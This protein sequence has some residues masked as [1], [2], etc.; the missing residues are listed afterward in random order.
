VLFAQN[1]HAV[2]VCKKT[3]NTIEVPGIIQASAMA[4][5]HL[6]K[7]RLVPLDGSTLTNA[8]VAGNLYY[9]LA[10]VVSLT[11]G[12]VRSGNDLILPNANG[13][14][15]RG[16]GSQTFSGYGYSGTH[17]GG[18]IGAK[19]GDA[20]RNIRGYI[21]PGE[22]YLHLDAGQTGPFV[23]EG[24]NGNY[25]EGSDNNNGGRV[26]FNASRVVPVDAVNH[27]ASLT[28]QWVISY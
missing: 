26:L 10:S 27:P 21:N 1:S 4:A 5:Q 14:Y 13:I 8:F 28:V 11:G 9:R 7:Y 22:Y 16:A 3:D 24:V 23:S 19:V 2:K 20:I 15:L 12:F 17:N 18:S 25:R 6:A